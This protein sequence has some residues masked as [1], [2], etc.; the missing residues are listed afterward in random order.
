MTL[1]RDENKKVN[2][3]KILGLCIKNSYKLNLKVV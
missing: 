3:D 2:F 1:L